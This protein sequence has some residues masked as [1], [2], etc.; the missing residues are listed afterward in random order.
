MLI[1]MAWFLKLAIDNHWIG[2]LGRVLVGL[3]AGVGLDRMVG[4]N[5]KQRI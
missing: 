4:A 2:P 1:G 3:I 5:P